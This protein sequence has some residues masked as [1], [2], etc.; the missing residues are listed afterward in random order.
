MTKL[1]LRGLKRSVRYTAAGTGHRKRYP[2]SQSI[3]KR[4]LPI[5]SQKL[6]EKKSFR[7]PLN[8]GRVGSTEDMPNWWEVLFRLGLAQWFRNDFGWRISLAA[9][10]HRRS[11]DSGVDLYAWYWRRSR[12][13]FWAAAA[14][15]PV[16][17]GDM[18]DDDVGPRDFR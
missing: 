17:G 6:C 9:N 3:G 2:I 15:P 8:R 11:S 10:S 16:L 5:I 1:A 12:S 7:E 14:N 18:A 13:G 4:T